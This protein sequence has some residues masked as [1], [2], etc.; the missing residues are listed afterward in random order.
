MLR[1][2]SEKWITIHPMESSTTNGI[3][4]AATFSNM[5]EPRPAPFTGAGRRQRCR[6]VATVPNS[7]FT[8]VDRQIGRLRPPKQRD[9]R[10]SRLKPK[11]KG[12][13]PA[14]RMP[15]HDLEQTENV[16][17]W[18]LDLIRH[19]GCRTEAVPASGG[20]SPNKRQFVT[21]A[22]IPKCARRVVRHT[23][24]CTP[25]PRGMPPKG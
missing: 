16:R 20:L 13:N 4:P 25:F 7:R 11:F 2:H 22:I 12:D 5:T 14:R 15:A 24:Q 10:A 17:K 18:P 19:P 6:F 8:A 21:S 9:I 3:S 1:R 23:H